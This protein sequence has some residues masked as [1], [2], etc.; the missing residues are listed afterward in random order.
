MIKASLIKRLKTKTCGVPEPQAELPLTKAIA[1][2]TGES[3]LHFGRTK[4]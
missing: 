4:D 3:L 1:F 2:N